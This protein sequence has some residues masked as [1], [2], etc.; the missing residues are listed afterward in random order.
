M[1]TLSSTLL[2]S[3]VIGVVAIDV[4]GG[5]GPAVFI[6]IVVGGGGEVV[7]IVVGVAAAEV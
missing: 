3:V 7:V 4:E 2:S 6:M 1:T 5:E